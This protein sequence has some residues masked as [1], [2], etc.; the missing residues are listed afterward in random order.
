MNFEEKTLSSNSIYKGKITE[1]EVQ[2][3]ELPNGNKAN[4]EIVRHGEASAIVPFINDK[5]VCVKQYRKPIEKVTIEIPAGLV[6]E[7]E[8]TIQAA[9]RELEEET[10]YKADTLSLITSFYT[11]P[12]FTDEKVYIYEANGLKVVDHPLEKDEDETIE[13]LELTY[14]QAWD[15]YENGL[16]NDSKTVFSLYYWRTK[17]LEN[18]K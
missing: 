7:G 4:R 16:I 12:G 10:A 8:S 11:T 15:A 17:R 14:G 5:L 2:E 3:V 18:F 13:I 6:D 1:Y 9:E